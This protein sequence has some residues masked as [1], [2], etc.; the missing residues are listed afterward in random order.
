MRSYNFWS[1]FLRFED[2][3]LTSHFSR[4]IQQV[5]KV[6]FPIKLYI[7]KLAASR[8]LVVLLL[9]S[10]ARFLALSTLHSTTAQ[11]EGCMCSNN[12]ISRKARTCRV[13]DLPAASVWL[14]NAFI[15]FKTCLFVLVL[16]TCAIIIISMYLYIWL[17]DHII[18]T[19]FL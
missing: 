8:Q 12:I 10:V 15:N 19:I 2:S 7:F 5:K 16:Q 6:Q 4:I 14:E 3:A 18:N 9:F 17:P 11:P 13:Y 1:Y